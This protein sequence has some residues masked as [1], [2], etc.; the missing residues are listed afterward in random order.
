MTR[1]DVIQILEEIYPRDDAEKRVVQTSPDTCEVNC[2]IYKR[3]LRS[4]AHARR[5]AEVDAKALFAERGLEYAEL[6]DGNIRVHL[7]PA[8]V[9]H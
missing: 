3:N 8:S 1:N 5:A 2:D 7:E 9:A 4:R 6:D